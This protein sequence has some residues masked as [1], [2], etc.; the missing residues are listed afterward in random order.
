VSAVLAALVL[1]AAPPA[2]GPGDLAAAWLRDGRIQTRAASRESVTD[3]T[4]LGSTWKLFVY[5]YDVESR[6]EAPAYHC[7]TARRAGEEYC[8]EPGQSVGRDA[9]LAR[10]CALYFEPL[11]L[12][13]EPAAWRRFWEARTDPTAAW[14]ADLAR[15]R[16]ETSVSVDELLHGLAAVPGVSRSAA[17]RALLPVQIDGYG[18][19]ALRHLGGALRVKTFTWSRPRRPG[20]SIG[21][22]AGWLV[23]GTPVW[24]SARGSSRTVLTRDAE[25]LAAWLPAPTRGPDDEPC[26]TV[27]FFDRYPIRALD[28]LPSRTAASPGSLRG[29]YRVLF[30]SGTALV[31]ESGGELRLEFEGARLRIRGQ[32]GLDEYVARVLDREADP[33]AGEA[34]RALAVVARTWLVQHAA[35]EGGC[36]RVADSTRAQRVSPSPATNAARQVSVFTDGIVLGGE[37][38][39]YRLEGGGPGVLAWNTALA[40]A[41]EGRRYDEILSL[42]FPAAT[43]AALTGE[44]ECLRLPDVEAWLARATSRWRRSLSSED[45]FEPPEQALTVCG[46]GHGSPYVDRSRLRV[47]VRGARSRDERVTLA[48]EYIHLGFRFHPHGDD[49]AFVE[50]IAR[51]LEE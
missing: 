24:F 13:I 31:F 26:V 18:Q 27:D 17:F 25:Q 42:A 1:L 43:L 2:A 6:A 15:L 35:F 23:D 29:R 10:S 11:R 46:L 39:R 28:R 5:A 41:R 45:G 22:G 40:Q 9:A 32:L 19:G 48:H 51:T 16:P 49:E 3:R 44:R 36:F 34:A 47:Y 7:G 38:V 50:R 30:E 33:G 14:L 21:G 12:G 4:P 20:T 37:D 8:C